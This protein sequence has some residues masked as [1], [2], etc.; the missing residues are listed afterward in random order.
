MKQLEAF[1]SSQSEDFYLRQYDTLVRRAPLHGLAQIWFKRRQDTVG[2]LVRQYYDGGMVVD[3]GCGNSVWNR[4]GVPTLGLDIARPM[5]RCNASRLQRYRAVQCDVSEGLPLAGG[6]V[7]LV[8]AT[9][10]LEH[11]PRYPLL[12]D[13]IHRVLR[14]GGRVI[15]SV[16]DGHLPGLWGLLF[17]VWCAYRARVGHDPYYAQRCGHCVDFDMAK[18]EAAFARYAVR[19]RRR[20][21][22][23]TAFLVGQ[24]QAPIAGRSERG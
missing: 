20:V 1:Y 18:L 22:L 7:S 6:S 17:P 23:L 16:P 2:E 13:E 8:V 24:K 10:I 21:M 3:V 12:V 15:A 5:L 9:E 4:G 11:L 19:E 14:V